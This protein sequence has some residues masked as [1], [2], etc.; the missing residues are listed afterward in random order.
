MSQVVSF[1]DYT[2]A[3]RFDAVPWTQAQIEEAAAST[4]P[5]TVI[6]TLTFD[7]PDADPAVPQSRNLTTEQA[8]DTPDLWY[9]IT[10]LD[11]NGATGQPTAPVQNSQPVSLGFVSSNDL[12]ARL[13]LELTVEEGT[14][15]DALLVMAFALI[16]DEARQTILLVEDDVLTMPGTNADHITLPQ[17]PVVSIASITLAGAPLTEGR[18]WYLDG[19]TIRR[20]SSLYTRG[21]GQLDG[22][23]LLGSAGGVGFGLPTQELVIT[24]THG[25]ADEDIPG[26][27]NTICLE[28]AIRCVVNP[29]AVARETVGNTT[30]TYDNNRFAPTGLLLNSDEKK[31]IRRL[32]GTRARSVSLG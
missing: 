22:P 28:S 13:G 27:I 26:S 31:T 24:Y 14:R 29:G 6:D 18:D 2:P 8:S 5:W 3:P 25:Y 19:D 15:A 12:A 17:R 20:I 32:F 7:T 10:F 11:D 4:G 1:V 16:Q 23:F 21:F 30:T 9:R